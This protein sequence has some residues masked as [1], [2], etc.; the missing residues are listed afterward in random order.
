M[1]NETLL[2]LC[3]KITGA[4]EGGVPSYTTLVGDFD[5]AGI[6]AGILQ[7]NAGSGT[8]QRLVKLAVDAMG[9]AKAQAY[10]KSDL[11]QFASS[12]PAAAI[13]FAK[14]HY[15]DDQNPS[16]LAPAAES[17]WKAFL[18]D[19]DVVA[20][21]RSLAESTV[22]ASAQK[23]AARYVPDYATR[24]RSIAFFFDLVTQEGSMSTVPVNPDGNGSEAIAFAQLNDARCA[25]L[26]QAKVSD[27]LT[28]IL[29]YYGY[30]RAKLGRAA[31]I[32]SCLSRRGTI[33]ARVGIVNKTARD[34]TKSLD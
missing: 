14:A 30:E 12:A 32:W 13:A 19:A 27:P 22:L 9:W 17:A 16:K 29:L 33:A 11:K 23:L 8:L 3:L 26:W 7:F 5:G 15:L 4:Y 2:D 6:S 34:F 25:A 10:F 18:G 31:Y 28:S 24:S 20:A 1:D 21:Q